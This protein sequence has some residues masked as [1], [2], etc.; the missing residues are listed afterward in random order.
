MA[1]PE[2][3]GPSCRPTRG[4]YRATA[5]GTCAIL[6]TAVT[7]LLV[8]GWAASA[9][10]VISFVLGR[11]HTTG[12]IALGC[13]YGRLSFRARQNT[14]WGGRPGL[15]WE[16]R[17]PAEHYTI[18]PLRSVLGEFYYASY[19]GPLTGQ[20]QTI[21]YFDLECPMCVIVSGFGAM[22][23]A[24]WRRFQVSL[25]LGL[26]AVAVIAMQLAYFSQVPTV[27]GSMDSHDDYY[28]DG[29]NDAR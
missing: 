13:Q 24:F 27:E 5:L 28:R 20:T 2:R 29:G 15:H 18:P 21:A 23:I 8:L 9:F 6:L 10:G 26:V 22:T 17:P 7:A 12:Q 14:P 11:P 16:P 1:N 25:A 3:L 4:H 19:S